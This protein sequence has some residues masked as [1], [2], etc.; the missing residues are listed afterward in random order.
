MKM[1]EDS[2]LIIAAARATARRFGGNGTELSDA[3]QMAFDAFADAC[4]VYLKEAH[5]D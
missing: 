3:L 5:D 4:E 1:S 2:K